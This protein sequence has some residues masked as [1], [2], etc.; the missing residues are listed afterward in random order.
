MRDDLEENSYTGVPL[1]GKSPD[2]LRSQQKLTLSRLADLCAECSEG[3]RSAL[4]AG[5]RSRP[6]GDLERFFLRRIAASQ[7]QTS[8]APRTNLEVS[9][10]PTRYLTPCVGCPPVLRL[11]FGS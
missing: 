11:F 5:C 9:K 2:P 10:V 7:Y 3:Q 6:K 8:R 4:R 1:H